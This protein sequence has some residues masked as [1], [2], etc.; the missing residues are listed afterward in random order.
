MPSRNGGSARTPPGGSTSSS[1]KT[2]KQ[3]QQQE[4]R[5]RFP[6]AAAAGLTLDPLLVPRLQAYAEG[7]TTLLRDV[8]GAVEHYVE[9]FESTKGN[10]KECFGK[11]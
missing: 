11:L 6:A 1:L 10:R 3:L 8:D 9:A 5:K 7:N 2:K 4:R